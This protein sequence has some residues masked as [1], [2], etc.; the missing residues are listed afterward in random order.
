[1]DYYDHFDSMLFTLQQKALDSIRW[2]KKDK[3]VVAKLEHMAKEAENARASLK[4]IKGI[5]PTKSEASVIF[6]QFV[7]VVGYLYLLDNG[8]HNFKLLMDN[9]EV[10]AKECYDLKDL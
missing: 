7:N 6:E 1:M 9:Y 2:Y 4:T 8:P 3:D 5:T 10:D